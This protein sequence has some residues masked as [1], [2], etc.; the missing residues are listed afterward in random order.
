L[1]LFFL[2][3]AVFIIYFATSGGATP[4]NYFIRLAVSFLHGKYYLDTNPPWLNELVPITNGRFAVVYPP[5]PALTAIPF[6][7]IFGQ[8]FQQQIMSQIMGALAAFVWGLIA[9]QKSGKKSTSL[10]VF[11]LASL[12]NIVWFMSSNGSVWYTG[13]ISAFLFLTLII[14]ESLNRKRLPLLILYF[15]LAVLSRLQVVLV[16]PLIIYL[17]WSQFK[18]L[19][20]FFS[21]ALGMSFFGIIYGVYNY[22]R[23]GSF[24]ET[25]YGLIPGVLKEPWFQ[26]GLFNIGYIPSHLEV[27]FSS[28][29]ILLK[30]FPFV[31][32]SWG[33]LSIWITSPVFVYSLFANFKKHKVQLS[34]LSI[35]LTALVVMSHGSTGFAQFGYRFAVDFYPI[36]L[37]L[38]VEYIS[39]KKIA[40]HHWFLLSVSILVNLWGVVF[41]NKLGFVGW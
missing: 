14:H 26:K 20:K 12:G 31:E 2:A 27:M 29:P 17:N 40:W 11:L 8:N 38:I 15:G 25:G 33:G 3:A 23:F 22:L 16:L 21:F 10:W 36:I 41:I 19:K 35:L 1:V 6:V 34:W 4:Y 32:P 37:F 13:Q 7:L 9:Y 5:A 24:L 39:G 30:K 28:L 18:N